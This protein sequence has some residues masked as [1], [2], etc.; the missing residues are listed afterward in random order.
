MNLLMEYAKPTLTKHEE[1]KQVTFSQ[2]SVG[3]AL[4]KKALD[5]GPTAVKIATA[6]PQPS[7]RVTT[8]DINH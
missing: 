7:P 3:D 5:M 2:H 6:R 8:K 4:S 1:L